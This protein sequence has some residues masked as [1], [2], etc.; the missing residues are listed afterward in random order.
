[1]YEALI[2]IAGAHVRILRPM[3]QQLLLACCSVFANAAHAFSVRQMAIEVLV[4]IAGCLLFTHHVLPISTMQSKHRRWS[5]KRPI[6][7][8]HLFLRVR[9][10]SIIAIIILTLR[11]LAMLLMLEIE[12]DHDWGLPADRLTVQ[13]P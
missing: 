6:S 4:T 10:L 1:M 7:S 11:Q 12:D 8:P 13:Q 3:L 9:L 2:N 5:A